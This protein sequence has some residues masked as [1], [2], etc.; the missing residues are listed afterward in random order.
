MCHTLTGDANFL[1]KLTRGLKNDRTN[2]H[3]SRKK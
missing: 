2:F 1:K 3:E